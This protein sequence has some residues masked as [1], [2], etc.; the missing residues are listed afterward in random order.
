MIMTGVSEDMCIKMELEDSMEDVTFP[1]WR[2]KVSAHRVDTDLGYFWR[3]KLLL[4]KAIA[5]GR[6]LC[7]AL[8]ELGISTTATRQK[9][10]KMHIDSH[11]ISCD[12][13]G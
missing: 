2:W 13:I 6:H 5:F 11:L 3:W 1:P 8:F 10:T 12:I 7:I 9:N 4:G